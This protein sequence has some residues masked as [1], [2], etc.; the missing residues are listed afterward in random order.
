MCEAHETLRSMLNG[1]MLQLLDSFG[2]AQMHVDAIAV[3]ES[4]IDGFKT[5]ARFMLAILDDDH[6]DLLPIS[7]KD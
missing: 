3:R 1:D 5:G 4:Y 2:D 6:G 7:E